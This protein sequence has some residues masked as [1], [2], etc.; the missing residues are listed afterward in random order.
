MITPPLE[1]TTP[2]PHPPRSAGVNAKT[3]ETKMPRAG[4]SSGLGLAFATDGKRGFMLLIGRPA[5]RAE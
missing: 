1:M 5:A 3:L 2:A 4:S